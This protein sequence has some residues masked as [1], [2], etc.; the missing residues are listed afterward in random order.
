MA[1]KKKKPVKRTK[2]AKAGKKKIHKKL[3]ADR[4]VNLYSIDGKSK[5]KI[6]LPYAVT[7]MNMNQP[8]F[9]PK[10]SSRSCI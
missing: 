7:D 6:Q 5:K 2:K 10:H 8:C 3:K 4:K 9:F 1:E